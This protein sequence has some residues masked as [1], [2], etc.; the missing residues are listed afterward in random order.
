MKEGERDCRSQQPRT[1]WLGGPVVCW[2]SRTAQEDRV[3]GETLQRARARTESRTE[4]AL[5]Q[6]GGTAT[7]HAAEWNTHKVVVCGHCLTATVA[8]RNAL[9]R[10]LAAIET[11]LHNMEC[12]AAGGSSDPDVLSEQ[13]ARH[14]EIDKRLR[15]YHY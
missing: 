7:T 13:C 11:D 10:D 14:R 1:R 8:L 12:A 6:T 2:K 5:I 3:T 9:V 15:I 4:L